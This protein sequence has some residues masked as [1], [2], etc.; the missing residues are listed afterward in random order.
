MNFGPIKALIK[1][2]SVSNPI[3]EKEHIQVILFSCLSCFQKMRKYVLLFAGK[4]PED[5]LTWE[6]R[7]QIICGIAEG[8]SYLH[9]GSGTKIIHRDI[10]PSNILLDE[11]FNPK[12]VDFGLSRYVTN[13]KAHSTSIAGTL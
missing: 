12:I 11:N 4:D 3:K 6:Q 1:S 5:V 2:F 10:K 9:G 8:L 7:F 13:N